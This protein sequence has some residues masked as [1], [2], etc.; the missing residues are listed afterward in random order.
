M[1]P[2]AAV[3]PAVRARRLRPGDPRLRQC[4]RRRDESGPRRRAPPRHGGSDDRVHR[5]DQLRL[6][7]AVD[8]HGVS[9]YP[10]RR[11]RSG[12]GRRRGIAE[13]RAAGVQPQRGQLVRKTVR[14]ARHRRQTFGVSRLASVVL[15]AGD[16]ARTRAHR[17]DHRAQYGPDRGAGRASVSY[18]AAA[19]RRIRRREPAA[20]RRR[21]RRTAISPARSNRPSPATALCS[22]T[23]TA[24]GPTARPMRW[25]S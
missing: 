14:R 17:S 5:A 7:H 23:T 22:I 2:A 15:H 12:A 24:C 4:H 25:P 8:R 3:A 11:V 20:A 13:P 16:R 1:R 6:R 18:F 19:G 21:R 9:L 10:R